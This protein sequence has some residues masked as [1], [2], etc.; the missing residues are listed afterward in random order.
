[1]GRVLNFQILMTHPYD[2]NFI[3]GRV[4]HLNEKFQS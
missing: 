1:M 2:W 3:Q 4:I